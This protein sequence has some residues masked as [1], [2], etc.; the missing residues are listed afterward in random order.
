MFSNEVVALLA[1]ALA[2]LSLLLLFISFRQRREERL[3]PSAPKTT[4][5]KP[6]ISAHEPVSLPPYLG[7]HPVEPFRQLAERVEKAFTPEYYQQLKT[8]VLKRHLRF[9]EAQ[10]EWALFELKRYFM[11]NLVLRSVPMFSETCD[12]IWHEMLMFTRE[13]QA[14][15]ERIAG[16]MIHHTP[17][18][19]RTPMPSEKA[20]FDWVYTHLFTLTPHSARLW[21]GF[22]RTRLPKE[23][24][25]FFL[26]ASDLEIRQRFFNDALAVRDPEVAAAIQILID[27]LRDEVHRAYTAKHDR[28]AIRHALRSQ[29]WQHRPDVR[30]LA[31]LWMGAA[32]L[33]ADTS[34]HS[35][36]EQ[37][38]SYC[39]ACGGSMFF[40]GDNGDSGGD[41]GCGSGCGSSCGSSC[42]GGCG[43]GCGS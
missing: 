18:A 13:Y 14:F 20:W 11:M 32:L 30:D 43:G 37:A 31:P 10:F 17:Y 24:V 6:P 5:V 26:H 3:T 1:I 28:F 21:R 39:G 19:E 9:S 36:H 34:S 27:Q 33:T 12:E 25:E 35:R 8:R 16:M 41:S 4:F 29:D 15:C 7:V 38:A 42:G 2:G 22:F 40:S 23:Q